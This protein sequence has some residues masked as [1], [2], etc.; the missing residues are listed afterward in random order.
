MV[1][2]I[3]LTFMILLTP[4]V[5]GENVGDINGDGSINIADVVYLFKHL[6]DVGIEK[7]DLNCDD[8]VDIA[9]VVY[10]FNNIQQWSQPVV[11]A[12][13]FEI[14]YYDANGNPVG[15]NDNWAYKIV[16]TKYGNAVYNK[17]C[18]LRKGDKPSS[19]LPSDVKVIHTPVK[20]VA[21]LSAIQ[22]AMLE[23]LNDD[24][25]KKS[26]RGVSKSIYKKIK[27]YGV[28]PDLRPYIDNG[29]IVS[30]GTWSSI[31]K[32]VLLSISPDIVFIP[33]T[34]GYLVEDINTVSDLG[35]NYLVTVE[36]NEPTFLG[37]AE[38][39]K[40]YAAF[41]NLDDKGND[42]LQKVW[43]KRNDLIR[44][45]RNA[46]YRPKVAMLYWSPYSGPWVYCAQNCYAKLVTEFKG[47]Y[48][49]KDI[50]GTSYVNLDKETTLEHLQGCEV[51]IYMNWNSLKEPMDTL[52]ELKEKRPDL[53]PI[54][55]HA[56]RVY[57][58]KYNYAYDGYVNMDLLM[59]D[60]ARMIHPECFDGGD[61]ELHY[62]KK[63]K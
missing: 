31:D 29:N 4:A 14:E 55:D 6:R 26:I 9:D 15:Y 2:K 45:T 62:F 11:F 18:I 61:S 7:G 50:P 59:E 54:L 28:F 56:K 48:M 25:V 12:K 47:D 27:D 53:A 38:W 46:D 49:F 3:L 23:A 32:D 10:L 58:S 57:V 43:K 34:H 60:F 5:F 13:N 51:F 21:T 1:K 40:V 16:T 8:S 17:Y 39:A 20:K 41:Y 33:W 63:L 30:I 19:N 22:V 24:N 35:L 37:K 42:F 36:S 52:E 44:I